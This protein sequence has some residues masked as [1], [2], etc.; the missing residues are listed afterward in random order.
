MAGM[1]PSRRQPLDVLRTVFRLL[2]AHRR[3][4]HPYVAYALFQLYLLEVLAFIHRPPLVGFF[5]P[6]VRRMK[7]EIYLHYPFNFLLLDRIFHGIQIPLFLLIGCVCAGATAW[8]VSQIND[9][10]TIQWRAFLR[11]CGR[12]YPH[13]ILAGL[14]IF[15]VFLGWS[16][17]EAELIG[18]A[19]AIR[20]TSGVFFLIKQ[21]VFLGMPYV[22]L[23]FSV[24]SMS[25]LG[26]ILPII[27][28]EETHIFKA[29][30]LNFKS[31]RGAWGSLFVALL[32]PALLFVPVILLRA[33]L[34]FFQT[35]FAPEFRAVFLIIAFGVGL[36][37]EMIQYTILATYYLTVKD[38]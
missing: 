10:R 12:I 24:L 35:T 34:S 31:L 3:I 7:G 19:A 11:R 32:I 2:T 22:R 20:S 18:R 29:I 17:L 30:A 16:R 15:L 33:N 6:L 25:L 36:F 1:R 28:I 26:G 38:A 5:G 37:I 14:L 4:T 23:F 13:L 21:A 9:E 27:T 8:A